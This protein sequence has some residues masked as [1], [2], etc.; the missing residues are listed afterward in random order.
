[1]NQTIS[2]LDISVLTGWGSLDVDVIVGIVGNT[3]RLITQ[4]ESKVCIGCGQSLAQGDSVCLLAFSKRPEILH[5]Y[6]FRCLPS[7]FGFT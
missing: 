5:V 1:M 2:C 6:H 3:G 4:V 7:E